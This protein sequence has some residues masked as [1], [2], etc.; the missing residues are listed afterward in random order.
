MLAAVL[1]LGNVSFTIIDNENHVVPEADEGK[2]SVLG[3]QSWCLLLSSEICYSDI[4]ANLCYCTQF[5]ACFPLYWKYCTNCIHDWLNQLF[6][7]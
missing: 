6:R 1:W 5:V 2:L 7:S 4:T 3:S